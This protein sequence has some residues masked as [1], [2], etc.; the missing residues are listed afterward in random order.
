MDEIRL[1]LDENTLASLRAPASPPNRIPED[2]LRLIQ[3]L[4]ALVQTIA[5]LATGAWVFY[6]YTT[7]QRTSNEYALK[8]AGKQLEQTILS[9]QQADRTL[10]QA[11]YELRKSEIELGRLV[12]TPLAI[13]HQI[14]ITPLA[15]PHDGR[16]LYLASYYYTFTNSANKPIEIS[17]LFADAFLAQSPMH[18]QQP[19]P[20][21]DVT[22]TRPL[23][24]RPVFAR[25]FNCR[26]WKPNM[27]L[28]VD[29]DTALA[30]HCGAGTGTAKSGETLQGEMHV[31]V[32]GEPHNLIKFRIRITIDGTTRIDVKDLAPLIQEK[33]R[34]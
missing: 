20:V 15:R 4:A 29:G 6:L 30:E 23:T 22:T 34:S 24:W 33:Q 10:R 7:F 8:I 21:N 17:Y 16:T 2:L 11:D 13:T 9:L 14:R 3:L 32:R 27:D 28:Q 5:V 1:S 18:P 25:A 12:Q 26:N 19:I 31:L